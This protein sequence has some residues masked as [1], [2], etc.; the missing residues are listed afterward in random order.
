MHSDSR[1]YGTARYPVKLAAA[2][3][4]ARSHGVA[5]MPRASARAETHRERL[6]PRGSVNQ[7]AVMHSLLVAAVVIAC[8]AVAHAGLWTGTLETAEG[9]A[10]VSAV[11]LLRASGDR[12]DGRWYCRGAVCPIRRAKFRMRCVPNALGGPTTTL[13]ILWTG[14]RNAPRRLWDLRNPTSCENLFPSVQLTL[15][16][17]D[18]REALVTLDRRGSSPSGAF[19]DDVE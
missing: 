8:T 19:L 4:R 14:R 16:L 5:P 11:G 2:A 12:F 17:A 13:G 10:S 6:T 7:S 15:F 3:V 18:G 1:P 9:T